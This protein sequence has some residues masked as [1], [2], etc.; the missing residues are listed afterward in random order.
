MTL[1]AVPSNLNLISSVIMATPPGARGTNLKGKAQLN[2]N[3]KTNKTLFSSASQSFLNFT[4]KK[5]N[6]KG[7]VSKASS[8]ENKEFPHTL[9]KES[10]VSKTFNSSKTSQTF[11]ANSTG[12]ATGEFCCKRKGVSVSSN[13]IGASDKKKLQKSE[14]KLQSKNDDTVIKNFKAK[15][16]FS[17]SDKG[18][19]KSLVNSKKTSTSKLCISYSKNKNAEDKIDKVKYK[20][21]NENKICEKDNDPNLTLQNLCKSEQDHAVSKEDSFSN[22]Y[23]FTKSLSDDTSTRRQIKGRQNNPD[24]KSDSE[25][26]GDIHLKSVLKVL[27]S[28]LSPEEKLSAIKYSHDYWQKI[29]NGE[30]ACD[31][32]DKFTENITLKSLTNSVRRKKFDRLTTDHEIFAKSNIKEKCTK[33][34]MKTLNKMTSLPV[35]L[36]M[37]KSNSEQIALSS[38]LEEEILVTQLEN[39]HVENSA[40]NISVNVSESAQLAKGTPPPK[41]PVTIQDWV[42]SID[43]TTGDERAVLCPKPLSLD[44]HKKASSMLESPTDNEFHSPAENENV[45][46]GSTEDTLTLGAEAHNLHGVHGYIAGKRSADASPSTLSPQPNKITLDDLRCKQSS[47]NSETSGIS[48]ISSISSVE[49]LLEAR[50]EDPEEILLALGF[51]GKQSYDPLSRIPQRFLKQHSQVRGVDINTFLQQQED[52]YHRHDN[53]SL[54][55]M[56]LSEGARKSK[57]KMG[58]K[59]VDGVDNEF[60]HQQSSDDKT[61]PCISVTISS[62]DSNQVHETEKDWWQQYVEKSDVTVLN[63]NDIQSN[64]NYSSTD[65]CGSFKLQSSQK[66]SPHLDGQPSS[67]IASRILD[68]LGS[69]DKKQRKSSAGSST[70]L[71]DIISV[72]KAASAFR[73]GKMRHSSDSILDPANREFLEKQGKEDPLEKPK[74]LII[75]RHT[76]SFD[77]EGGLIQSSEITPSDDSGSLPRSKTSKWKMMYQKLEDDKTC[78]EEL[79]EETLKGQNQNR[80]DKDDKSVTKHKFLQSESSKRR[81]LICRQSRIDD[82]D[83]FDKNPEENSKNE[84]VPCFSGT[85]HKKITL[86]SNIE[87]IKGSKKKNDNQYKDSFELDELSPAEGIDIEVPNQENELSAE[88]EGPCNCSDSSGFAEDAISENI[89]AAEHTK[90]QFDELYTLESQE[91]L[92][93]NNAW[94]NNIDSQINN[95]TNEQFENDN[96][97]VKDLYKEKSSRLKRA[98]SF[99]QGEKNS[100]SSSSSDQRRHS[101][102]VPGELIF[103]QL[104]R[105]SSLWHL[106]PPLWWNNLSDLSYISSSEATLTSHHSMEKVSDDASSPNKETEAATARFISTQSIWIS[107]IKKDDKNSDSKENNMKTDKLY[108]HED[109]QNIKA[110]TFQYCSSASESALISSSTI[111]EEFKNFPIVS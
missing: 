110:K 90:K 94:K 106:H 2:S 55:Y 83:T 84:N 77:Q 72:M 107:D 17:C 73:S 30:I 79:D 46:D 5:L 95:N 62:E 47:F 14:Q 91:N 31:D 97:N 103:S 80:D 65:I 68:R 33:T 11:G 86:K 40:C 57:K 22:N 53:S 60:L 109:S 81:P 74:R 71:Q 98:F 29:K 12:K 100:D 85:V 4:T 58:V 89:S 23:N 9:N 8:V 18:K 52:L 56:G 75:G 1:T 16:F 88:F 7:A 61:I 99:V 24:I 27:R 20:K 3:S 78:V 34:G 111:E 26:Y 41:S 49:S 36:N 21:D 102:I 87:A 13:N 92:I 10:F 70:S 19:N 32:L 43:L 64:C 37:P 104:Q 101:A 48:G 108:S 44:K 69:N 59:F 51:G 96:D 54:G 39:E 6:S 93:N 25:L 66:P 50:R 76:Y 82:D 45:H 67:A 38:K 35:C 105:R 63:F 42:N 28:N 15:R